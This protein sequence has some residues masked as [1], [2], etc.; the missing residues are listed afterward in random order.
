MRHGIEL[1][2]AA[3]KRRFKHTGLQHARK[4]QCQKMPMLE[5]ANARKCQC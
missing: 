3:Q 4:C 1:D 5:N 2:R